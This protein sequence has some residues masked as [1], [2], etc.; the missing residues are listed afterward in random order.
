ME[1]H[2]ACITF[3][4]YALENAREVLSHHPEH[5]QIVDAKLMLRALR[6]TLLCDSRARD[7]QDILDLVRVGESI[8][9]HLQTTL[10]DMQKASEAGVTVHEPASSP[11]ELRFICDCEMC[12]KFIIDPRSIPRLS[13]PLAR[14]IHEQIIELEKNG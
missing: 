3:T 6:Y 1:I 8:P 9:Y 13:T 14:I 2:Q 12:Q 11:Q 7:L 10:T 4:K 5:P